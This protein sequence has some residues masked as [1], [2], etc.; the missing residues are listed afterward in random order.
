[1]VAILAA[2][3]GYELTRLPSSIFPTVT[4]PI[5]SVIADVGEEPAAQMMPTVTRPLEEALLRVPG[6]RVVRSTTAR[7]SSELTAQFAWGTDMQVAL[8]RVEAETARVRTT[9]PAETR[10]DVEWM[11]PA[12][13][14]ILGYALT[15]D[16]LTQAELRAHADFV[17]V[18]ALIRIPGVAQVQIQGGRQREFRIE[19]DRAALL[20]RGLAVSDVVD[21][22]R[23]DQQVLSAG[24]VEQNH[25]LY[26]TL[27]D[28]RA[29]SIAALERITIPVP[30][31]VPVTLA[32]LGKVIT[33]DAVSYVRTTANGKP[34]VLVNI[35]R[36]PS[37][38][39]TAIASAVRQL[40]HDRPALIPKG[41]RWIN[42][43]DQARFVGDAISGTRDAVMIGVG[44]AFL[45]LLVFL[46]RWRLALVAIL[47]VPVTGAV[48][49]AALAVLGQSI[50]LMTL[51]GFAAAIGLVVDDAIVVVENIERHAAHGE[52]DPIASGLGELAPA[53]IGSSISTIVILLPF[54][55][56]GG[57]VGAFFKPLAL[58]MAL[59][60]AVSFF[61][62]IA[63]VPVLVGRGTSKTRPW[64]A[65][66]HAWWDRHGGARWHA[67]VLRGERCYAGIVR[68]ALRRGLV[69][70]VVA[71]A[72]LGGAY[73]LHG[74]LGTDF[75]P[76]MD[77][78]SIILDYWTPPGTSL[79]DTDAMLRHVDQVIMATPGVAAY[80]RRTGTQLG[81]FITEPNRGDYVIRLA[82]RSSRSSVG[83][84]MDDLR[85]RIAKVEP[86]LHTDFGQLLEDN[87]GD[88][89][90]GAAQPI[91]IK[92][93]G[94]DQQLL[95]QR[96]R[97]IAK[98]VS[99]VPG[100]TDVFDGIVIAGP[101]L[102]LKVDRD[103]AARAGLTTQALHAALQPAI[104]GTVAGQVLVGERT[105][106]LR[107]VAGG[108][109]LA[110]LLVRT[111][112]G[113]LLPVNRLVK[114]QTGAPETE[115]DRE[116]L[117]TYLAITARIS[118]RDLGSVMADIRTK[119]SAH[120]TLGPDMS[121]EYGGLF[122]QQQQSFQGL[123]YVLF[124]GL[125]LVAAVVLLEFADW[126]APVVTLVVA[127]GSLAGVFGL[128]WLTGMTLNISSFVAAIMMVGITG[129]NA[130]F[131]IHEARL[132]LARGASVPEAW[133]EASRR[134]AR[135][136]AMTV[137]AT[138]LA[139]APLAL[140]VGSGAQLV[141]PIAIG[142]IGG[143]CVSGLLVLLV[144]PG[145]YRL[146]DPHGRLARRRRP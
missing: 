21:A 36:Q 92:I 57:V 100:V 47:A 90:G 55:L 27:V 110:S 43:Y 44:L 5:V 146:L 23:A 127:L 89:T 73:L 91:E 64:Q 74:A 34:A 125:V 93:F 99:T 50:N 31:G 35:V 88:L 126:R 96:A 19:L 141:Q 69:V 131:V 70:A 48:V 16:K 118:G 40:L 38:S 12:V 46:R 135:P 30:N 124:A 28:G 39:T 129:E 115:I 8:Q 82:P 113:A 14:P 63:L 142:V 84:I 105:Y 107:V 56:L 76:S 86:V 85:A 65:R 132:G 114:I 123:L 134:R 67:L 130:I 15:S 79:S 138:G 72:L 17:L 109:D 24:L 78:G 81:F 122:A 95:E 139:L 45:V 101:A 61:L 32:Q 41:V 104:T 119:I 29:D 51:A 145:L 68:A 87:I 117:R 20:G 9:L 58:T 94:E 54:A 103:A 116:S 128:Q 60:L 33:A 75:L 108:G 37:A 136:V 18:P 144:V 26:L 59:A 80:S 97:K 120:I 111:P 121:I 133:L 66:L 6:I 98:L 49:V 3:G 112:S 1:M 106:D 140:G 10:I 53:M 83:A 52:S 22:V 4:F 137:L 143:F 62:A 13:F 2:A 7:G 25:E 11:N 42:F 71:G 77:E 102:D